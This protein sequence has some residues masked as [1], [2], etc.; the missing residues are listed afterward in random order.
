MNQEFSLNNVVSLEGT[1][2]LALIG[3]SPEGENQIIVASGV[4]QQVNPNWLEDAIHENS[5][6]LLQLELSIESVAKAIAIGRQEKCQ[7]I[8]NI[9]PFNK[10]VIPYLKEID[11]LIAN[12]VEAKDIAIEFGFFK[13]TKSI[14]GR[15][16]FEI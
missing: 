9:A 2:G 11:V 6:L 12:E 7:I 16:R 15:I 8:L 10:K 4:N 14:F 1:T 3:I 13:R 5:T